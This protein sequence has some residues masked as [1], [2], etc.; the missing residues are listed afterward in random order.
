MNAF[1]FH[2]H[3][4]CA[5]QPRDGTFYKVRSLED[6]RQNVA[7]LL[8]ITFALGSSPAA[9][10]HYWQQYTDERGTRIEY[11]ADLFVRPERAEIGEAFVTRDGRARIHM[12]SMPNPKALG[13]SEFMRSQFPASRSILTYDRVTRNFFAISTRLDGMIVYMRCNFS[14]AREGSLHCVDI[15]YPQNEKVAWDNIVTRIS[16]SVRPLP[17]T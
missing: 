11:P 10:Q 2:L 12:Y 1:G 4:D 17:A 6:M 5:R 9:A 14:R 16:R 8:L 15:R 3:T 7:G 13:P